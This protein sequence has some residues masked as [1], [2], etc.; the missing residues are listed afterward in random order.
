MNLIALVVICNCTISIVCLLLI[1]SIGR[2]RQ[3]LVTIRECC[4][5][6][7][8]VSVD[9]LTDAPMKIALQGV[10]F[11]QLRQIYRQQS[12]VL[13]RLQSIAILIQFSRSILFRRQ[14][15]NP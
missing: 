11:R 12:I 1:R 10:Q 2:L 14:K 8:I 15:L 5:R 13:D 9:L 3:K 6:W 4:D 7:T